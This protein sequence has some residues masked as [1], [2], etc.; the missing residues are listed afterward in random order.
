MR[1]VPGQAGGKV[2]ELGCQHYHTIHIVPHSR[3][4]YACKE[5][6]RTKQGCWPIQNE[7]KK[8]R[9]GSAGVSNALLGEIRDLLRMQVQQHTEV[10]ER[11][12]YLQRRIDDV[13]GVLSAIAAGQTRGQLSLDREFVR[14]HNGVSR[15]M[16]LT[17]ESVYG[18]EDADEDDDAD[19]E[20]G[21]E[22]VRQLR[23]EMQE[24]REVEVS[25]AD[26]ATGE[27]EDVVEG[28]ESQ[29]LQ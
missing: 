17:Y 13:E 16:E 3:Q 10:E 6:S 11:F 26:G 4:V 29:T 22:E 12:K 25:A 9:A 19:A 28:D 27:D 23:E 1:R 7:V 21:Q 20:V 18:K 24:E 14:L 15:L 5:C 8:G 2:T